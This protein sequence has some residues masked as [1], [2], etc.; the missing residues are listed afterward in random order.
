MTVDRG[1][2]D[3]EVVI[4]LTGSDITRRCKQYS[5]KLSVFQQPSAFSLR[6]GDNTTAAEIRSKH[7]KGDPFEL[8]IKRWDMSAERFALDVPLQVGTLDA[9]DI[10]ETSETVIEMRGRDN[11]AALFDSYFVQDDSVTEATF[12]DLTVKQLKAVGYEHTDSS[13]WLYTGETGRK[14]AVTNSGGGKRRSPTKVRMGVTTVE[15]LDYAYKWTPAEVGASMQ[16]TK[17]SVPSSP[18]STPDAQAVQV[19]TVTGGQ[20]SQQLNVLRA[21][22]G[23]QRYA[24]LKEQYKKV[25]LF[26]WCMPSGHF[27]LGQPN[28]EQEPAFRLQRKLNGS[29]EE[30]NI[31]SGGLRDDCVQRYS[32]TLVYGR[33]GGGKEGRQRI[34]GV[35]VD[36][37]L[38][39]LGITKQIV[40]E[41][42]TVKTKDAA[43]FLARRHA[44][45]ARRSART[46]Q[47]TVSGHSLP[48]LLDPGYR[49]PLWVNTVVNVHD[50]KLGIDGDFYLG[51]V[52]FLMDDN[53]GTTSRLTL[54]WPED[55]VFG[56]VA[57]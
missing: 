43:D 36:E 2:L 26:L 22:V 6:L 54:Y 45:D 7:K 1:W 12:F 34:I 16:L 50:D 47:Y 3:D 8:R 41:D 32:H 17:I 21:R 24:W 52:E 28:A 25:G 51:D 4:H 37:E 29:P 23:Q 14:K 13:P 15:H 20:P 5:I 39:A 31:L 57:S 38:D 55:L 48:S 27:L 30:N 33:R 9:V 44:A 18:V 10:P 53:G 56:E 46:L 40:Y 19:E 49:Y 42:Q 11:M 35:Y